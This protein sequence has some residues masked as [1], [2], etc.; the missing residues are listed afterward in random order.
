MSYIN[1]SL[2]Y[3]WAT[4]NLLSHQTSNLIY[5]LTYVKTAGVRE[6]ILTL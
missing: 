6:Y 4:K 5:F 3:I 2:H 1:V